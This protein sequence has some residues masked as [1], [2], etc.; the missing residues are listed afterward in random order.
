M[1]KAKGYALVGAVKFLRSQKERAREV[2]AE[3][4]H[5]Y[6]EERILGASWYPEADLEALLEAA[7]ALRP[8][9]RDAVLAEMGAFSAR[10]HLDGGVY[11]HLR[12]D[13]EDS[14]PRRAL[15][16]WATQHDTGRWDLRATGPGELLMTIRDFAHPTE[17]LCGINTG[18][19]SEA[20]RLAGAVDVRAEKRS[21]MARG[22]AEC[23]WRVTFREGGGGSR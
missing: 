20:L 11:R 1:A 13:G 14:M 19:F 15:A 3:E 9:P 22:D 4:R 2:L 6:L 5:H 17:I 8:G 12:F 21:C 23:V 16:L 10:Q 18:Y 7:L